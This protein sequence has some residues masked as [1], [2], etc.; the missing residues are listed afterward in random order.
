MTLTASAWQVTAGP[1]FDPKTIYYPLGSTPLQVPPKWILLPYL[2][3]SFEFWWVVRPTSPL[4]FLTLTK[5][6]T[7]SSLTVNLRHLAHM[8]LD[9]SVEPR[10]GKTMLGRS[11]SAKESEALSNNLRTSMPQCDQKTLASL[12]FKPC[13]VVRQSGESWAADS[14]ADT[15]NTH[16]YVFELQLLEGSASSSTGIFVIF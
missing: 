4:A 8:W 2:H 9:R 16:L 5:V 1:Y 11:R 12:I 15:S 3:L 14:S 6:T 10:R 13:L 7:T